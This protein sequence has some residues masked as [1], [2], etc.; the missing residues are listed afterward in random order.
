M[1]EILT[2]VVLNP[3]RGLIVGNPIYSYPKPSLHNMVDSANRRSHVC[4]CVVMCRI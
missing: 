1:K 4:E 3:F 2:Q